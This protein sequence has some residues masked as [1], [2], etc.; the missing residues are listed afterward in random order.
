LD[1][2]GGEYLVELE[3]VERRQ[4]RGRILGY[5]KADGEPV[6]PVSLYASPLRRDNFE[7]VLQKAT[8]LGVSRIIPITCARSV[9]RLETVPLRWDRI[10]L[11]AAEQSGRGYVPTIASPLPLPLAIEN[12]CPPRLFF[13]EKSP[14]LLYASL[15]GQAGQVS[16]FIGPE[17]GFSDE[18]VALAMKAGCVIASLGK[19]ILRAETAAIAALSLA[20]Y[21]MGNLE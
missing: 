11:E 10:V 5:Q 12:S 20:M 19:H 14:T 18:E 15:L 8:E 13:H 1:G 2:Q 21:L 4:V 9:D 16:L 3:I 6:K 17:G 7:W